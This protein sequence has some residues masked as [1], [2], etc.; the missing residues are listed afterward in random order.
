MRKSKL[1]GGITLLKFDGA[2]VEEVWKK[3]E[4]WYG[5]DITLSNVD[6]FLSLI[7]LQLR[8]NH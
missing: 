3:L 5:V 6:E 7:G 1:V 8:R 4:R 2:P